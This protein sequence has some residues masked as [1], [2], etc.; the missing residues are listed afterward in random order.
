MS[1]GVWSAV[2]EPNGKVSTTS[3]SP[4]VPVTMRAVPA[5]STANGWV[6]WPAASKVSTTDFTA[7]P[8]KVADPKLM[9]SSMA[10]PAPSLPVVGSTRSI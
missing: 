3:W 6:A 8:R 1:A 9:P 10:A 5:P 2:N 4:G 7:A